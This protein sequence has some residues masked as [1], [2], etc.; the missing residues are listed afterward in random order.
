MEGAKMVYDLLVLGGG[1]GG[2]ISAERAGRAGLSTLLIEER[3]LGGV[4]LNEGCIPTKTFL[5]SAKLYDCAKNESMKYGVICENVRLDHAFV[6]ERKRR[7]TSVLVAGV[8]A[9]MKESGVKVIKGRG[10]IQGQSRGEFKVEVNGEVYLARRLIVATGSRPIIPPIPGVQEGIAEGR[11]LFSREMLE[12]SE[13]PEQL[14]V[15]GAGVIGLEL[16]AYYNDAGSKV[17]VLELLDK[18]AG[19]TDTEISS[20]L[21]RSCERKGI[22]FELGAQMKQIGQDAAVFA[23]GGS[24]YALPYR[25][26]LLSVGRKAVTTGFGLETLGVYQE[27]GCVVI[28]DRCQTNIANVYAVGD[29]TGRSMLAHTAYRQGE[30]AV[31]HILG[32]PDRMSYNAIPA[33]IYTS[34]EVGAVGVTEDAA[35]QKGLD[36]RTVKLPLQFSGRYLAEN[37]GGCGICKLIFDRNKDTLVGA[38]MLGNPAS[39]FIL[40]CGIMIE[41]EMTPQEIKR[42]VFPHPTVCEIIREAVFR[43]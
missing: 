9:A 20:A 40:A 31:N 34:P 28:N 14:T 8:N 32:I 42:F 22:V 17:T 35:R 41:K 43:L 18:I 2:Y 15:I 13:V 1:P 38:H 39:E 19:A 16:A 29:C 30:V 3:E 6:V 11:V 24:E 7:V 23:R 21:Q 5:H 12:L 10:I 4:C 25:K 37:E 27:Y 36:I 26:I 33:V